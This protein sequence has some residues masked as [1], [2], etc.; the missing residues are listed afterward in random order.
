MSIIF[1][2]LFHLHFHYLFGCFMLRDEQNSPNT[3]AVLTN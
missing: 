2:Y 3:V 1:Y